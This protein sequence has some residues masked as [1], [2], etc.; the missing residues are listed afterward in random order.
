MVLIALTTISS[1]KRVV[2]ILLIGRQ[3]VGLAQVLNSLIEVATIECCN[4]PCVAAFRRLWT[5]FVLLPALAKAQVNSRSVSKLTNGSS[6]DFFEEWNSLLVVFFP[7]GVESSL[8]TLQA[9]LAL[10]VGRGLDGWMQ[11]GFT[12]GPVLCK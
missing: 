7:E 11:S 2:D 8:K 6:G 1:R 3:L 4:S 10:D 12:T 5:A 9:G